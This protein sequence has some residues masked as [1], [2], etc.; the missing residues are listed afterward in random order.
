MTLTTEM[1]S[2][3]T[4]TT[5]RLRRAARE[6]NDLLQRTLAS[7]GFQQPEAKISS[8]AQQYWTGART[9]QWK[10][11]SH[12]QDCGPFV[13]RDLWSE[14]GRRHLAMFERGVR[15][16]DFSRP[17]GRAIEWG[18]G[19]GANAVHFAPRVR[20]FIGVEVSAE[21][22][23]ECGRQVAAT[24]DTPFRPVLVDVADPEAALD[25]IEGSCDIFICFY[26]FELIPT[27]EYGERILRIAHQLIAPGGLALIQIKYDT[28]RWRTKPRRRGYRRGLADMTTYPIASFWELARRSGL[29][30][31]LVQLV[32]EDELDERYAYFLLSKPDVAAVTSGR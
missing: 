8:Q 16:V 20:E 30:P 26:V 19:G 29:E 14:I 24:C 11:N 32:P 9:A 5:S 25:Q 13:G 12:W 15:T 1:S 31:A 2:S 27:P 18:C 23:Q 21:S 17:W 6:V 28:G 7:A 3:M 22:L 10:S 4:T